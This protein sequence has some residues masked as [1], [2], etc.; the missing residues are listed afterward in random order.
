LML[1][2]YL[3]TPEL[4]VDTPSFQCLSIFVKTKQ[5]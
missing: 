3:L 1:S 5:N 4:A 2:A